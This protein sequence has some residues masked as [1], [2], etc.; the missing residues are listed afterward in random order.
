M[1]DKRIEA[2]KNWP[3]L[4]SVKNI[5]V[6]LG[7]ANFYQRF[8]QGFSKIAGPLISMLRTTQSAE[9]LSL[10]MS[11]DGEVGSVGGGNCEDKTV[12]RSPLTS[13]NSNRAT[14][15]LTPSTK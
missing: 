10:L 6:F 13:K 9:N 1:E 2:I 8:I 12:K 7:F 15:S 11:E 5:R 3:K 14:G 4:K